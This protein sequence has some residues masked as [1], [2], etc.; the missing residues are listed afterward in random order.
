M[1]HGWGAKIPSEF[2]QFAGMH[3]CWYISIINKKN[4]LEHTITN[5]KIRKF[6]GEGA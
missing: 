4:A 2:A 3:M 5:E 6:S 1:V